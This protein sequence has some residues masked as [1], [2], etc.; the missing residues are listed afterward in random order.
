M[1]EIAAQGFGA[2][3]SKNQSIGT[4]LRIIV[5][6][7]S[8]SKVEITEAA[9]IRDLT[10]TPSLRSLHTTGK[11]KPFDDGELAVS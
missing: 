11:L 4:L 3:G 9:L 2:D 1:H 6:D 10:S 5:S 7:S 8:W